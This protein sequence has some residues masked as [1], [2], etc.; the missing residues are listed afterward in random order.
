MDKELELKKLVDFCYELNKDY[1]KPF[2]FFDP[3][4]KKN[5]D[6]KIEILKKMLYG[7]G[8]TDEE[9]YDRTV[10]ENMPEHA[11]EIIVN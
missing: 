10:F 4:S 8:L 6:R 1:V 11:R 5:I 2:C 3:D 7:D 9:M